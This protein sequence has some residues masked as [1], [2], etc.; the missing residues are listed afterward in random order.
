MIERQISKQVQGTYWPRISARSLA[1]LSEYSHYILRQVQ[2]LGHNLEFGKNRGTSVNIAL[3]KGWM[4]SFRFPP[5][6][7]F[8]LS[9][10][11]RAPFSLTYVEFGMKAPYLSYDP[12]HYY[13]LD[14]VLCSV[15]YRPTSSEL[16]H[17]ND[18]YKN[19]QASVEASLTHSPP[20]VRYTGRVIPLFLSPR[21]PKTEDIG[22]WFVI[23]SKLELRYTS[24]K[25]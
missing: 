23:V 1:I 25:R 21:L 11:S 12:F 4:A 24:L 15:T 10:K 8:L 7:N 20:E 3:A 19:L 5:R 14:T 22:T 16:E 6:H 9:T 2:I 13:K 17:N 18:G